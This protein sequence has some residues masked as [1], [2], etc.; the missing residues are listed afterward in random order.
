M[1]SSCGHDRP[2][3]ARRIG[4]LIAVVAVAGCAAAGCRSDTGANAR[5]AET[6]DASSGRHL[7]FSRIGFD[8]R[9]VSAP[10]RVQVPGGTRSLAIVA[11]GH[12]QALFALAQLETA[13]GVEHVALPG[14]IDLPSALRSAYFDERSGEMPGAVHQ[15]IRLGLF[16]LVFPDR[17]GVAL[18]AGQAVLRIATSDPD[19]LVDVQVIFAAKTGTAYLPVNIIS[20]SRDK[21][22]A[23]RDE[24]LPFVA[25]LRA[26]LAGGGVDLR[27]E[28]HLGMR[29]D[30][31]AE[32]TEL[33]EPQEPPDSA[34]SRLA[35]AGG[36]LTDGDA[37]NLFIVDSLPPGVGGWTLGTPGPPLPDTCYSGVVAARLGDG[38]ELARIL[39][40]E[41]GHY[42]G[43]WHV[44]DRSRSG[45]QML[46]PL[47]DTEPGHGNLMERTGRGT[48]LTPDQ[49]AVL[50]LHPLLRPVP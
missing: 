2:R 6:D 11:S 17:P 33:S 37:L 47:D 35:L 13:D 21:T 28:R 32:L 38:D 46:D 49:T 24:A 3:R 20:V 10:I 44:Q 41:I 15:T 16:T 36:A 8:G 7:S 48:A 40:H 14:D 50:G 45:A 23:L 34:S 42:L 5:G 18:P 31:L 25:P 27:V 12:R 30:D 22:P 1:R 4:V 43:L 39:A 9:G 29:E 19:R 26:I